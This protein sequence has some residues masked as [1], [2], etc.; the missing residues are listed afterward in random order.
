MHSQHQVKRKKSEYI[1]RMLADHAEGMQIRN[2]EIDYKL[3]KL[4]RFWINR[5]DVFLKEKARTLRMVCG[6][7]MRSN[8][9]F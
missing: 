5:I 8:R 4:W 2:Q 3:Q 9:P 7:H 6:N 1:T